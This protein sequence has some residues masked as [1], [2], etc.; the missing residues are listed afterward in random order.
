MPAQASCVKEVFLISMTGQSVGGTRSSE[1]VAV[2]L[3]GMVTDA[4]RVWTTSKSR[5]AG[6]SRRG[7]TIP[8]VI[9]PAGIVMLV[10]LA[11]WKARS[12]VDEV[13]G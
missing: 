12:I 9:V 7:E 5:S 6:Q 8:M 11:L 2:A 10:E 13:P 4:V 3:A 1:R